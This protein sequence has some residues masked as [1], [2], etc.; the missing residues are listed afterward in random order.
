MQDNM[1]LFHDI[2]IIENKNRSCVDS[3]Y[4]SRKSHPQ[5]FLR[6][7]YTYSYFNIYLMKYFDFC[8][9]MHILI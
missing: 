1:R 5:L 2:T 3:E 4:R 7:D 6:I 8:R 9:L